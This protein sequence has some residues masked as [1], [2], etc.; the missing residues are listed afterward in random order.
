[1]NLTDYKKD[2][3]KEFNITE[4]EGKKI[5][6]FL[7]TKMRRDLIFGQEISLREIGKFILA[8]RRRRRF[9][10]IKTGN[11]ELTKKNS[12][13]LK[14]QVYPNLEQKLKDK[15]VHEIQE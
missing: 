13:Y 2:L 6:M 7:L 8:V 11:I 14:F 3:S 4:R 9:H 12:F 5:I 1:M 10:N 15:T